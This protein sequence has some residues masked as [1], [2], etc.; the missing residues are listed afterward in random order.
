MDPKPPR[1]RYQIAPSAPSVA[2]EVS[3]PGATTLPRVEDRLARPESRE[4]YVHGQRVLAAPANA[5]HGDRHC[6]LDYVV[7]G[8]VAAGYIS[9]TDLLTRTDEASDFATDTCVRRSGTD[10]RTGTRWLEE[11]AFE[12]VAE[13]SRRDVT[14]R[15]KALTARGVRRL[16]AVFVKQGEVCEWSA[17]QERWRPLDPHDVIV[18][19]T[20]A[21]PLPV[22]AL[23]D[24]SAADEA[25]AQ[26]LRAR[27]HP[28]LA[29]V[30]AAGATRGLRK[31]I[32][33]VCALLE[34][35][36]DDARQRQL[37]ALDEA[38]LDA[39]LQRLRTDRRWPS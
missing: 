27:H 3:L 37:D 5:P 16:V 17:E 13:Q 25:V 11:L 6:Q 8:N 35:P 14:E 34:L 24:A 21:R 20:L 1:Y 18:D 9:S 22:R 4:E 19:P 15:A 33:A 26:G 31:G 29:Q 28:A 38:G 7:R 30:E 39:L 10:P 36:L 23:L 2:A 32:E 12:V